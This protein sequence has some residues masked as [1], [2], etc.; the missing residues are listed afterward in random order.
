MLRQP[1]MPMMGVAA[2]EERSMPRVSR[3]LMPRLGGSICGLFRW[4]P[5]KASVMMRGDQMWVQER[6]T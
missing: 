4:K 3:T 5:A 1:L 6:E 2:N